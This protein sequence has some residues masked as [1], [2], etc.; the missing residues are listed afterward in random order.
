MITGK[1]CRLFIAYLSGLC[2]LALVF[3]QLSGCNTIRGFPNPPKTSTAAKP[4]PDWQL[5]PLAIKAYNDAPNADAQKILRNDIIDA[6]VAALDS[7][8]GD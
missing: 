6:R 1:F 5:G 7:A 2:G 8:F 4:E 3:G